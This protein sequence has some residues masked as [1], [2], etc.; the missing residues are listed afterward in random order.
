VGHCLRMPQQRWNRH[1]R[2]QYFPRRKYVDPQAF[3]VA[4]PFPRR[5]C[6]SAAHQLPALRVT[7]SV[8]DP[9]SHAAATPLK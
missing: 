4:C 6:V 3:S 5:I 7:K 9:P 1:R 8:A 2:P